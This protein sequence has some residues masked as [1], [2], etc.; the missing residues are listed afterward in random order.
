VLRSAAAATAVA[1]ARASDAHPTPASGAASALP[2][3]ASAQPPF[4]CVINHSRTHVGFQQTA[5][6]LV[7][8]EHGQRVGPGEVGT[9]PVLGPVYAESVLWAPPHSAIPLGLT[10][11]AEL[12]ATSLRVLV[13]E[14]RA[15]S[16]TANA[17]AEAGPLAVGA[18]ALRR[19]GQNLVLRG[20]SDTIVVVRVLLRGPTHYIV[21]HD[22]GTLG[23]DLLQ[24][25]VAAAPRGGTG[26]AEAYELTA[27]RVPSWAAA[28]YSRELLCNGN[29]VAPLFADANAAIAAA[30]ATPWV[31][32]PDFLGESC[33]RV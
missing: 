16:L 29:S 18:L 22:E 10:S 28:A 6:R 5:P 25:L 12:E 13:V 17:S 23:P 2:A 21:V 31:D 20:A 3:A 7:F 4:L 24:L 14:A 27:S 26:G 8:T 32:N 9:T 33:S 30:D 11:P 1:A 19:I 15:G